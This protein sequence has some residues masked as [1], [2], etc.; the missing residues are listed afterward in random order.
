[1]L[2]DSINS[3]NMVPMPKAS[4]YASQIGLHESNHRFRKSNEAKLEMQVVHDG[5][6]ILYLATKHLPWLKV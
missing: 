5:E 4:C 6:H 1:M 2:F 3:S